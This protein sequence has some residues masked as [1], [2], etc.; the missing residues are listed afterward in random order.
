MFGIFIGVRPEN[1]EVAK[2]LDWIDSTRCYW[3]RCIVIGPILFYCLVLLYLSNFLQHSFGNMS[4]RDDGGD[5]DDDDDYDD[6]GGGDDDDSY[7]GDDADLNIVGLPHETRV[8]VTKLSCLLTFQKKDYHY[9]KK[10][11]I[12]MNIDYG[13][14]GN[15]SNEDGKK[16]LTIGTQQEF[17]SH[18]THV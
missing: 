17:F 5:C 10:L 7:D 3:T 16:L 4:I 6:E 11:P 14:Y 8:S 15:Y 13:N 18:I 2:Y 9:D 1:L 12:T